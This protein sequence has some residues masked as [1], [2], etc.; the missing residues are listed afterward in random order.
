MPRWS[1]VSA[2][3]RVKRCRPRGA[4][5]DRLLLGFGDALIVAQPLDQRAGP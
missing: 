4:Y 5:G 1:S 3:A 2:A